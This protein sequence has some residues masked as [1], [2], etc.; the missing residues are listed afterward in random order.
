MLRIEVEQ[1]RAQAN[2]KNADDAEKSRDEW[3]S[4]YFEEKA[5][6][7]KLE[8]ANAERQTESKGKDI[9][10]STLRDQLKD[11]NDDRASLQRENERLRGN[12]KVWGAVGFGAGAATCALVN[13]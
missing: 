1:K 12:N 3:K 4:L 8:S 13:R 10:I 2:Q 7:A 11:A 5:R 6:S 9:A